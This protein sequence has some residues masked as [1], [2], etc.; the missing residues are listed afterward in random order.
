MTPPALEESLAERLYRDFP[1]FARLCLKIENKKGKLEPFV[2]NDAQWIIWNEIKRQMDANLP[3]RIIILKGRQQGCSTLA[4]GIAMWLACTREG[5]RGMS[6]AHKLKPAA[7][8]L[9]GKVELM[10]ENLPGE[11]RE[12]VPLAPGRAT[13]RR[14]K[15][16]KPMRSLMVVESAEE[17]DAVGRSGTFNFG[18]LTEIPFWKNAEATIAAFE[19]C[20]PSEPGTFIIVESTAQGMGNWFERTW[21]A[22][23]Q[24]AA[25]KRQPAYWPVFVPWFKQ[26][27]YKRNRTDFDHDLTPTELAR[28]KRWGLSTEQIL[29]YR[30]KEQKNGELVH[31]E[32]P[33][34]PRDAFLSSG[35][36]FF[37]AKPL[38][39]HEEHAKSK[40]PVRKGRWQVRRERGIAKARFVENRAGEMWVWDT[41]RKGHRYVVSVDPSSGRAKDRSAYHVLDVTDPIIR[42]VASFHGML[43]PDELAIDSITTCRYYNNALWVPERNAVGERLV[44]KGFDDIG[45][46]NVYRFRPDATVGGKKPS[47]IAG[48]VSSP[49]TRPWALEKLAE[50]VHSD[51]IEINCPRTVEEMHDFVYLDDSEKKIGAQAGRHDDLV[52]ALAIGVAARDQAGGDVTYERWIS[53]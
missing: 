23:E 51:T 18:H 14:L 45:Y 34:T 11:I 7:Q 16:D 20:V 12:L 33:D 13:G 37:M 8:E 36:P 35:M 4:Q 42:Q 49:K 32:Y 47:T 30:D 5:F 38:A 24:A 44:G 48:W 43:Q 31:Q 50:A 9:F 39:R 19:A 26:A 40:P 52:L 27:E 22:C 3:V 10:Y 2:L 46:A 21:S 15:F 6:V 17:A 41:P 1:T 28:Q 25:D 53:A 29:W